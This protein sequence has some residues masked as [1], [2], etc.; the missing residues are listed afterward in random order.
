MSSCGCL[1]VAAGDGWVDVTLAV[2][3]IGYCVMSVV[4]V[5]LSDVFSVT[6]WSL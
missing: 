6:V 4:L 1:S 3:M 5:M 2:E